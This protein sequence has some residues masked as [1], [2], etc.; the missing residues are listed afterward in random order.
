MPLSKFH[1]T[2]VDAANSGNDLAALH[3]KVEANRP[4]AA[5]DDVSSSTPDTYPMESDIL[6]HF[7][8]K[9]GSVATGSKGRGDRST[10]F[11]RAK[12]EE[13]LS[14][15]TQNVRSV[16][17]GLS[18]EEAELFVK[19][20]LFTRTES[21]ET[22]SRELSI[23]SNAAARYERVAAFLKER[24]TSI[25]QAKFSA[26]MLA[27]D[28]DIG[29]KIGHLQ[30]RE[31]L[32]TRFSPSWTRRWV[33]RGISRT[34]FPGSEPVRRLAAEVAKGVE[35]PQEKRTTGLSQVANSLV[36]SGVL[37]DTEERVKLEE[38]EE[39]LHELN[40]HFLGSLSLVKENMNEHRHRQNGVKEGCQRLQDKVGSYYSH[41]KDRVNMLARK[42]AA[43][44]N[45]MQT[46]VPTDVAGGWD[47]VAVMMGAAVGCGGVLVCDGDDEG[48]VLCDRDDEGVDVVACDGD[49]DFMVAY[50]AGAEGVVACAGNAEGVDGDMEGVVGYDGDSERVVVYDKDVEGV[51]AYDGDVETVVAYG[52]DAEGVV[53]YDRDVEGVVM[54]HGDEQGVLACDGDVNGVVAYD[55]DVE[56]VYQR[57]QD[58]MASQEQRWM[59]IVGDLRERQ[60]K[61]LQKAA[62]DAEAAVDNSQN[63][64]LVLK[65]QDE[66]MKLQKELE[67]S[68][69]EASRLKAMAKLNQG[70]LESKQAETAKKL[71][72]TQR[73]AEKLK[74]E[75]AEAQRLK[76]EETI[77]EESVPDPPQELH[78]SKVALMKECEMKESAL[79]SALKEAEAKLAEVRL[80]NSVMATL[81][82]TR[83]ETSKKALEQLIAKE[84][85]EQSK[86]G[87]SN[88][89]EE[90]NELEFFEETLHEMGIDESEPASD[91]VAAVNVPD[92][93]SANLAL[94]KNEL[95]KFQIESSYREAEMQ[96]EL[97]VLVQSMERQRRAERDELLEELL[98]GIAESEKGLFPAEISVKMKD[99]Q[100]MEAHVNA[101]E[102]E[103]SAKLAHAMDNL[104]YASDPETKERLSAL[105]EDITQ[106][107]SALNPPASSRVQQALHEVSQ[108]LYTLSEDAPDPATE[109]AQEPAP[110]PAPEPP[111]EPPPEPALEPPPEPPP[112]PALDPIPE[113]SAPV[114]T[115]ST[116]PKRGMLIETMPLSKR[117][118]VQDSVT[119]WHL[120][121]RPLSSETGESML[122]TQYQEMPLSLEDAKEAVQMMALRRSHKD[123]EDAEG[124]QKFRAASR[125]VARHEEAS[126]RISQYKASLLQSMQVSALQMEHANAMVKMEQ[127]HQVLL[128][129]KK[130][131][132]RSLST[133]SKRSSQLKMAQNSNNTKMQMLVL[134]KD[135]ELR[136]LRKR[137]RSVEEAE[138]QVAELKQTWQAER[139]VLLRGL[140]DH[141]QQ[142]NPRHIAQRQEIV[143]ASKKVNTALLARDALAQAQRE[144]HQ[145]AVKEA[146]E[147]RAEN[148]KKIQI[149]HE[150]KLYAKTESHKKMVEEAKVIH[151]K[152]VA[153]AMAVASTEGSTAS[154]IAAAK[155]L[156]AETASKVSEASAMVAAEATAA[157]EEKSKELHEA[158]VLQDLM[159]ANDIIEKMGG[160]DD[161]GLAES[162]Q[163]A[164]ALD[165]V[166]ADFD[167]KVNEIV[168]ETKGLEYCKGMEL[169][170]EAQA[171]IIEAIEE[172]HMSKVALMKECEMK[173]SALT[174]A[175]KEAEAKL[176]E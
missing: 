148:I 7:R 141:A 159:K 167:T 105:V 55:E 82:G 163:V 99:Y 74:S 77:P 34:N 109:P 80:K 52:G 47:K 48:V 124:L 176:A 138:D 132:E 131:L 120:Q 1:P 40:D 58:L 32:S 165:M 126:K 155:A 140:L 146:N 136:L 170:S 127:A 62:A 46:E 166:R 158:V 31:I 111:P 28:Q 90:V 160:G 49:E 101:K 94:Y 128:Y 86:M 152:A 81:H 11:R 89:A 24:F 162:T 143:Q 92:D 125:L 144:M 73:E 121:D 37:F 87:D 64:D 12:T 175:L 8:D 57:L 164:A 41:S 102:N 142:L 59:D 19:N 161:A 21:G 44:R 100:A 145:K 5:Q 67:A 114:A 119:D 172:L 93:E 69:A 108:E 169:T 149:A 123:L 151:A 16:I 33:L 27:N 20:D 168:S 72:A 106:K 137:V 85:A 104:E 115:S 134:K 9:R 18:A 68:K 35:H 113:D 129:E 3:I 39:K 78:M 4:E 97:E 133:K 83:E 30:V 63:L 56:D 98:E 79:T 150:M 171:K 26:C 51:V 61:S 153:D 157:Q 84:K 122:W 17:E 96:K 23:M 103:Y 38:R 54:C 14:S 71:N 70:S 10:L 65:H 139:P 50:D 154:E 76:Q 110:E 130:E 91:A 156:A 13:V 2:N 6:P 173:E 53:A 147:E 43:E 117:Y 36:M 75:L 15:Q 118:R 112:E 60:D 29:H 22:I 66:M 42:S 45:Q 95:R 116:P 25:Q 88:D 107:A 135:A 174:S